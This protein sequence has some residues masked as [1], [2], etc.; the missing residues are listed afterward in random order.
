MG[1]LYPFS[2]SIKYLKCQVAGLRQI[3]NIGLVA[4]S[5][6]VNRRNIIDSLTNIL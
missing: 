3:K 2:I 6:I 4:S 5:S 1:Y